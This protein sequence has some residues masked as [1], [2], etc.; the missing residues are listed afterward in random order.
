MMG[1]EM[2]YGYVP[3]RA[4]SLS[5]FDCVVFKIYRG[6]D[7][8]MPLTLCIAE[9]QFESGPWMG[10]RFQAFQTG[11]HRKGAD[12]FGRAEFKSRWLERCRGTRAALKVS[13]S[14]PLAW[15]SPVSLI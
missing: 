15:P 2:G 6:P 9:Q 14:L 8:Y 1:L 10:G 5:E 11:H 3:E 7:A 13:S 4:T 12:A